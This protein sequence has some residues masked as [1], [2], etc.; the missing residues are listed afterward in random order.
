MGHIGEADGSQL[1]Q[2]DEEIVNTSR[3]GPGNQRLLGVSRSSGGLLRLAL[4]KWI[5]RRGCALAT[6]A[7]WK[8]ILKIAEVTCP[9]ALYTAASTSERIAF[10]TINRATGHRVHRQFVDSLTGKPVDKEDQVKGYEVGKGDYIILEPQEIAAVLPDSDKT[11]S[12]SA[13]IAC[14][15][16]DDLYFGRPYY[17]APSGKPAEEAFALIREGMRK[18]KGRG[19]CAGGAVPA[20]AYRA[21]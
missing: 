13:F 19:N 11:L 20:R 12:V 9:V 17:L 18:K 4:V 16:V 2:M 21:D 1:E 5:V 10:H 15:D 6:R 3:L 14:T 7:N 8:G